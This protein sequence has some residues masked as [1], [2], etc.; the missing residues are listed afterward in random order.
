MKKNLFVVTILNFIM[1]C[2]FSF[3]S[4]AIMKGMST[5]ELTKLSETVIEGRVE[6]VEAQWSKDG[7]TIFTS[8]YIVVS[9]VIRG[10]SD[11]TNII[12][13]YEGGEIGD[14]GVKVSDEPTLKEGER[15]ILFLK[16]GKSKKDGVAYNIVGK[17]QG[18]YVMGA[19]GIA[20]KS[21]FSIEGGAENIDTNIPVDELIEKVRRV[22]Q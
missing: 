18:K 2:L 9:N 13:E 17:G 6:G 15:V 19:D 8:A 12:V 11:Q 10:M 21:G 14:T 16:S 3:S 22:K 5:K 20:R 7:K 4:L 1:L